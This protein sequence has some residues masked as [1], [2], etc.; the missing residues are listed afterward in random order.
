M[1][2]KCSGSW[3]DNDASLCTSGTIEPGQCKFNIRGN[4]RIV[5]KLLP[6]TQRSRRLCTTIQVGYPNRQIRPRSD[7]FN[8]PSSKNI[9]LG[10][11]E[12]GKNKN[13]AELT[14]LLSVSMV[15]LRSHCKKLF[16]SACP[17]RVFCRK[18]LGV[19]R[20]KKKSLGN[21]ESNRLLYARTS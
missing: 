14:V 5:I 17:T 9:R 6:I 1:P 11:L 20:N 2:L 21:N 16:R 8:F 12:K 13:I 10:L 4:N 3:L 15:F 19:Q 7:Q 18:L